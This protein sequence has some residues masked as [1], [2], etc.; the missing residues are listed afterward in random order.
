MRTPEPKILKQIVATRDRFTS[1][2]RY[3]LSRFLPNPLNLKNRRSVVGIGNL[4]L[5]ALLKRAVTATRQN[6]AS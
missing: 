3:A 4:Y 6:G 5:S 1:P 2:Q